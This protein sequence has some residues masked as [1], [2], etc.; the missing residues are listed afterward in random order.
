M[1]R[2][3]ATDL[4]QTPG[5]GSAL[6]QDQGHSGRARKGTGQIDQ[7][8]EPAAF[9]YTL[10]RFRSGQQ[11]LRCWPTSSTQAIQRLLGALGA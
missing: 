5:L 4:T 3:A 11:H 7:P 9:R 6:H 1:V 10:A 2:R 8:E